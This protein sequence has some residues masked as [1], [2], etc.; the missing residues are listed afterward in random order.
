MIAGRR[1]NVSLSCPDKLMSLGARRCW[2]PS[3][4]M[5]GQRTIVMITVRCAEG[6]IVAQNKT[7]WK[8]WSIIIIIIIIIV[9]I[10]FVISTILDR[11]IRTQNIQNNGPI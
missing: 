3:N 4:Y 5:Y 10:I 2:Q 9:I 7:R 11:A 8:P 1:A 6:Y